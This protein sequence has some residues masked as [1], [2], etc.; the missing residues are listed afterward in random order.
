MDCHLRNERGTSLIEVIVAAAML[1]VVAGAVTG[2]VDAATRD[3]GQ[4]RV[5]AVAFDLAQSEMEELR[6]RRFDQ[7]VGLD[8]TQ[9]TTSGGI[10]FQVQKQTQWSAA[11]GGPGS[12]GCAT[13]TRTARTMQ[14]TTTV[15]WNEMKRD[16]VRITSLVAAPAASQPN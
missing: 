11:G 10:D 7:L 4:T 9:A 2:L 8:T 3:S 14:V 5:Q 15:T 12:W 6:S 1:L 13:N 16:P